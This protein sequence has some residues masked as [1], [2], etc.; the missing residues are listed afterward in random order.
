MSVIICR[1]GEISIYNQSRS[2]ESNITK[3]SFHFFKIPHTISQ[4]QLNHENLSLY[5]LDSMGAISTFSLD[6]F[7]IVDLYNLKINHP[8]TSFY[9]DDLNQNL[10]VSLLNK[11]IIL[12]R[13]N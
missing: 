5:L 12:F 7:K 9:M 10:L 13:K 8:I 11:Q 1:N 3:E 6:K 4:V 2:S